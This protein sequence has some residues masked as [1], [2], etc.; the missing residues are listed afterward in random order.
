MKKFLLFLLFVVSPLYGQSSGTSFPPI[1]AYSV[2][3]IV[4][5]D[6]VQYPNNTT[7]TNSAIASFSTNPGTVII[8]PTGASS[9][10]PTCTNNV[11]LWDFRGQ[12]Q[13]QLPTTCNFIMASGGKTAGVQSGWRKNWYQTNPAA[14]SELD[15][16]TAWYTGTLAGVGGEALTS[17]ATTIGAITA[18]S[19]TY[20]AGGEYHAELQSTG[21]TV[22]NLYSGVFGSGIFLA[23]DTTNATNAIGGLFQPCVN[24]SSANIVNCYGALFQPQV[25]G[26]T[27]N[28]D[29]WSQGQIL[30]GNGG[31]YNIYATDHTSAAQPWIQIDSSD[32]SFLKT[33]G[34]TFEMRAKAAGNAVWRFTPGS[35]L[36]AFDPDAA[37]YTVTF[38]TA[39]FSSDSTNGGNAFGS[40]QTNNVAAC[41]T[42][43]GA[44]TLSGASTSTGLNC[45]PANSVIDMVVYR[46]TTT[47][48]TAA[49]FTIGDGGS[50]TR[51][52]G[53]QSTLTAG[54]TGLCSAAGYYLNAS[55]GAIVVTPN[56]S[57]GAG[58]IRLIVYYHTW[59]P[60]TS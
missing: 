51:Y 56:T 27:R 11:Y 50:A 17:T 47:I 18:D 46:I 2:D 44:T 9:I 29:F 60:P 48:T 52:C 7:G 14:S 6:G 20:I 49:S 45:L 42:S 30:V 23:G 58:A 15:T 8:P 39:S 38:S 3:N 32:N 33:V 41:E 26:T 21:G 59:A 1:T 16:D 34:G 19:N 22:P 43:F 57:P 28:F 13:L 25:L 36:F 35:N 24:V 31:G 4:I 55:A 5:V 40:K 12:A 10:A 54:T 53:T 37:G